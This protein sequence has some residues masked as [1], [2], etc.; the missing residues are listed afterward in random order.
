MISDEFEKEIFR[1]DIATGM[2][3][4]AI[5]VGVSIGIFLALTL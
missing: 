3:I 2:V 5:P 1:G 4:L